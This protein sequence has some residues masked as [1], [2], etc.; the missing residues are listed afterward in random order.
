MLCCVSTCSQS[1]QEKGISR[2]SLEA[3]RGL[4]NDTAWGDL[5]QTPSPPDKTV[6]PATAGAYIQH[7][8]LLRSSGKLSPC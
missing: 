6:T 4:F 3:Q 5:P 7:S 1:M 8:D 2:S